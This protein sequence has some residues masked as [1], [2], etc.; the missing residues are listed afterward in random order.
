MSYKISWQTCN[1]LE[2]S[3]GPTRLSSHIKCQR[4]NGHQR[5]YGTVHFQLQCFSLI[6]HIHSL[7][8][9]NLTNQTWP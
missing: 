2:P 7:S 1:S 8:D 5:S 9:E 3:G 6:S 4:S